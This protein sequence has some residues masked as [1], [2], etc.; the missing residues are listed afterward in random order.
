MVPVRHL[1]GILAAC[2]LALPGCAREIVLSKYGDLAG[3]TRTQ[4]GY[5]AR[6]PKPHDGVDI[7]AYYKGDPVIASHDGLVV[8]TDFT[9]LAGHVVTIRHT[10]GMFTQYVHLGSVSVKVSDNVKR[11]QRIGGVGLFQYSDKVIHVHWMLCTNA[12]CSGPGD[13]GGT[14]DPLP[15]TVGCF[16]A[17]RRYPYRKLALTYPV[18]CRNTS[19]GP[20]I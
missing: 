2:L 19:D 9:E 16:Q 14:K 17:K 20:R 8:R 13:L 18:P 4:A 11:G 6:R 10:S 12:T 7:K 1:L 15:H 5:V 3:V